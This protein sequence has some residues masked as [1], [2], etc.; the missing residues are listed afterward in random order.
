MT[1][2][3]VGRANAHG[4]QRTIMV[5]F[6]IG[7]GE[8]TKAFAAKSQELQAKILEADQ[9]RKPHVDLDPGASLN[10]ASAA[11]VAAR[12]GVGLSANYGKKT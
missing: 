6:I 10:A 9:T 1:C 11:D 7:G 5:P 12:Y 8:P 4:E 2:T 3:H